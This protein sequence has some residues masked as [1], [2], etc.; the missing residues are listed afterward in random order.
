VARGSRNMGRFPHPLLVEMETVRWSKIM[1]DVNHLKSPMGRDGPNAECGLRRSSAFRGWSFLRSARHDSPL[2]T[3]PEGRGVSLQRGKPDVGLPRFDPSH[4]RLRRPHL[5]GDGRLREPERCSFLREVT[6][7][8]AAAHTR[9]DHGLE[10]GVLPL[11][12][13]DHF[14]KEVGHQSALLSCDCRWWSGMLSH[15]RDIVN[16]IPEDRLLAIGSRPAG[17]PRG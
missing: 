2:N 17:S 11:S 9:L 8:A 7:K 1:W 5:S 4:R 16:A 6:K 3:R 10:R 13:F 14:V 12:F 15:N